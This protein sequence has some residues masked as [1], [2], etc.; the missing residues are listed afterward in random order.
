MGIKNL[1]NFLKKKNLCI[2][3]HLSKYKKHIIAVDA[4]VYLYKYLYGNKNHINGL[5]FMINK[6]KKYKIKPVFIFDG[7]PPDEKLQTITVRKLQKKKKQMTIAK[8]ENEINSSY[9]DSDIFLLKKKLKNLQK[10]VIYI[11]DEVINDSKKLFDVMGIG[12][13]EADCEA[14]HYCSKLCRLGLVNA[15]LSED[16]D[17]IACGSNIVLREF[18]N[19]SD[20]V[21]EYNLNTILYELDVNY[22]SFIDICIL[23]GNDYNN[24]IKHLNTEHILELIHTHKTIENIIK[25][26][27]IKYIKYNYKDIRAIFNLLS[28]TPDINTFNLQLNKKVIKYKIKEFLHKYS[29]IDKKVYDSRIDLMYNFSSDKYKKSTYNIGDSLNKMYLKHNNTTYSKFSF[30]KL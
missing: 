2:K 9:I 16:T 24:K 22:K 6:L 18:S 19:K 20:Y 26:G 11:T 12:Y 15:V 29:D 4:N 21:L 8:L 17:T 13:I 23:M 25:T 5:F 10:Q 3:T 1:N 7:K 27:G 30:N 14:E 28:I